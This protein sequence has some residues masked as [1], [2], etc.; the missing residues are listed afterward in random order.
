MQEIERKWLKAK[1]FGLRPGFVL[2]TNQEPI[3]EHADDL[4][5]MPWED[6]DGRKRYID[7]R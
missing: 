7:G 3:A 6:G 1:P 5:A 4:L 2:F